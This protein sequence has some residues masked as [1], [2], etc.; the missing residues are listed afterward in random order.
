MK[1]IPDNTGRFAIRPHYAPSDLDFQCED[2]VFEFLQRRHGEIQFPFSTDDI[3]VLIE[4]EASDLDS[5]ADLSDVGDEVEGVTEFYRGQK[6]R[7]RIAAHLNHP[8]LE[9]RL[10]TTLTH[11]LAHVHFHNYLYQVEASLELFESASR[12]A[13]LRCNRQNIHGVSSQD[14][15]E[16]QARYASGAILM[17]VSRVRKFANP[18]PALGAETPEARELITLLA[19]AFRVSEDAARVRLSQLGYLSRELNPPPTLTVS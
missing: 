18:G 7:V 2:L 5:S 3:S 11:E 8:S 4:R 16:W 9:N 14:W 10:R 13:P 6:P 17:P 1:F 15:M 12:G 19:G